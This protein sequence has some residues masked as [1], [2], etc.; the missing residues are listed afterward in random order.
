MALGTIPPRYEGVECLNPRL[1]RTEVSM[2][3]H[4]TSDDCEPHNLIKPRAVG[5]G[6]VKDDAVTMTTIP[7]AEKGFD[8]RV[9]VSI[10]LIQDHVNPW[11]R[12]R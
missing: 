6:L 11:G 12:C 1:I 4:S 8:S 2:A 3:E 7:V 5:R 9:L 10:E